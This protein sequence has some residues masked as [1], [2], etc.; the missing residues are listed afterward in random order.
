MTPGKASTVTVNFRYVLGFFLLGAACAFGHHSISGAYFVDQN[1]KLE[2]DVLEFSYKNPHAI[3]QLEVRDPQTGQ[4]EKWVAEWAPVRRL[5]ARGVTKD[6]IKAGD[7][8]IIQGNPSR[9]SGDHQIFMR[10]VIRP[11]DGW[12]SGRDIQ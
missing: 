5:E 4:V 3:L 12:K 9:K 8:V 1:T 6:S 7:H 11:S 10:G 2:G